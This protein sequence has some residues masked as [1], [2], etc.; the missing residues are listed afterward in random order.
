MIVL[1]IPPPLKSILTLPWELLI[2]PYYYRNDHPDRPLRRSW[3]FG[4]R[5]RHYAPK[6]LARQRAFLREAGGRLLALLAFVVDWASRPRAAASVQGRRPRP[7]SGCCAL[8][9]AQRRPAAAPH[10]LRGCS[11]A[12]EPRSKQRSCAKVSARRRRGPSE[13]RKNIFAKEGN[14]LVGWLPNR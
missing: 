1:I 13:A 4:R 9:G 3:S 2:M 12:A 5:S 10:N 6:A 7:R 11:E 8:P 14:L